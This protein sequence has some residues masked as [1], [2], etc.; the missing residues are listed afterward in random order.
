MNVRLKILT[1][2][3]AEIARELSEHFEIRGDEVAMC[4]LDELLEMQVAAL[5]VV[6]D[7][8]REALKGKH[9]AAF[10]K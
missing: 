4:L 8:W 6:N 5:S 2:R 3:H 10:R 1:D 7:E 9:V